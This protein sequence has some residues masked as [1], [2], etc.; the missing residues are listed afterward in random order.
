[1]AQ[2]RQVQ[3]WIVAG[4]LLA[5]LLPGLGLLSEVWSTHDYYSHGYLVPLFSLWLAWARRRRLPAAAGSHLAG[6][7][8]L[9]GAL[10][11]YSAGL[12]LEDPTLAGLGLVGAVVGAVV[13]RWGTAGARR[14]AFPLAFLLFMV[15]VPPTWLTP[16]IVGLQFIVSATAVTLVDL[17]GIEVFRQ[18]NVIELATGESLFVAEAC[19]GITS[20]VTLLPLGCVL[21]YFTE[22]GLWKRALIVA[23]VI[24]IAMLGNL[25]RVVATIVAADAWGVDRATTGSLHDSAG[26]L[27]F[28]LACVL[29]IGFGSLLRNDPSDA[30]A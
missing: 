30:P 19:S 13:H 17:G 7:V 26:V 18:G 4:V 23:A 11:V 24:P 20:I 6:L 5:A 1:M 9:V 8:G 27:T 10:V 28:V 14:L 12:L 3:D 2:G 15:P 25:I 29:L 16:I 22:R 21:A